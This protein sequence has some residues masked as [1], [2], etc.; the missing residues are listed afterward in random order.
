MNYSIIQEIKNDSKS[1]VIIFRGQGS[2][3][4]STGND[5]KAEMSPEEGREFQKVGR[6][7]CYE[8]Y[9]LPQV[10][11]AAISGYALAGGFE[12]AISTDFRLATPDSIFGL[13]EIKIG[14]IP[15]W[16]GVTL[17]PK[18]VGLAN[19]KKIAFSTEKFGI[20]QAQKYGLITK[21]VST[22]NFD[23]EVLKFAKRFT[24]KNPAL[25]RLTKVGMINSLEVPIEENIKY[26]DRIFDEGFTA[27][28][29]N[30]A[31]KRLQADIGKSG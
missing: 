16:A 14:L 11:I 12:L 27:S 18:I 19:A 31:F 13:P 23:E 3:A 7:L 25:I 21:V 30:E 24:K 22:E 28:N 20:E 17:L 6:Q 29:K 8:I 15:I 1:G 10:T 9:K 26:T 5:L 4:F 2:K